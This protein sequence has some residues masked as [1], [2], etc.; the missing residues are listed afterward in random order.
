MRIATKTIEQRNKV[1]FAIRR[2]LRYK[3]LEDKATVAAGVGETIDVSSSG[4]AF[5]IDQRLKAGAFIEISISWPVLLDESCPM[6]LIVFGRVQRSS[7]AKAVCTVDKY[8][9]RT[10]ARAFQVAMPVRND[11][12]LQR[13]ADGIRRESLRTREAASA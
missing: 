8:E 12:M 5:A 4:V 13:W 3:L 1:R 10:Q 9:F 2:E 6:R 11:A 7:E